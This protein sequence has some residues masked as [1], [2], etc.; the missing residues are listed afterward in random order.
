MFSS[1][2][3][4]FDVFAD[5]SDVKQSGCHKKKKVQT[6]VLQLFFTLTGCITAFFTFFIYFLCHLG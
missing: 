6:R 4:M 1:H 3:L 5:E 2:H